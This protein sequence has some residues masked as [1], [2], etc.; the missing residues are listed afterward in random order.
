MTIKTGKNM[1]TNTFL[2]RTAGISDSGS[3]GT[4]G[5]QQRNSALIV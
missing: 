4:N 2:A 1:K 3:S 5:R